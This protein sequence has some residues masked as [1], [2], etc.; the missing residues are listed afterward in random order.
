M[1]SETPGGLSPSSRSEN[2][3]QPFSGPCVDW[4]GKLNNLGYGISGHRP[5]RM[6][7]RDAYEAERGPIPESRCR[8]CMRDRLRE[9]IARD[10]RP[11]LDHLAELVCA[12]IVR[13]GKRCRLAIKAVQR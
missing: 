10:V 4:V 6:A 7:H 2:A 11:T 8:Q 3:Q 13:D 5:T 9:H 1:S 12:R